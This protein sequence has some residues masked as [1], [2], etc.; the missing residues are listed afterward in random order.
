MKRAP[1]RQQKPA[2][3]VDSP[4]PVISDSP[5]LDP[6]SSQSRQLQTSPVSNGGGGGREWN[7]FIT[8]ALFVSI[9]AIAVSLGI[10]LTNVL[11]DQRKELKGEID[12]LVSEVR[13]QKTKLY[14]AQQKQFGEYCR[15]LGGEFYQGTGD[16]RFDRKT[17]VAIPAGSTIKLIDFTTEVP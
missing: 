14:K 6:A 15:V 16:C 11:R 7:R 10:G 3:P 17:T 2:E 12:T 8:P 1:V 13:D 9:I 5:P 4:A